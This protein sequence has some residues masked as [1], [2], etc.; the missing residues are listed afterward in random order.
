MSLRFSLKADKPYPLYP[1]AKHPKVD[2]I[3]FC[4]RKT[5][6]LDESS[7][8][9]RVIKGKAE[10]QFL[11]GLGNFGIRKTDTPGLNQGTYANIEMTF[12]C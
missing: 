6:E 10:I 1:L 8:I 2:F 5:A 3:P 9:M 7:S 4:S 12:G 11:Q